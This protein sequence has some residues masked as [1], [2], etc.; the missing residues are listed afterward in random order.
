MS[1]IDDIARQ[2][3]S[4]DAIG[5][6][7]RDDVIPESDYLRWLHTLADIA[8]LPDT[9][10]PQRDHVTVDCSTIIVAR[11]T[12]AEVDRY[13][14][15]TSALRRLDINSLIGYAAIAAWAITVVLIV[16]LEQRW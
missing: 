6:A 7:V 11:D 16:A 14:T 9:Y 12:I 13:E 2:G 10:E 3:S 8:T 1:T 4:Y 15:A 5:R